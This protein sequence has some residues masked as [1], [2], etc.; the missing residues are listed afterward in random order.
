[1]IINH[2]FSGTSLSTPFTITCSDWVD[3]DV[4]GEL[5]QTAFSYRY[6]LYSSSTQSVLL[7]SSSFPTSTELLLPIGDED[8][9]F[10]LTLSVQIFDDFL[11]FTE[12]FLTVKVAFHNIVL[13]MLQN[14]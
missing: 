14:Y 6:R 12:L 10:N 1:M 2:I 7:Y 9:D 8:M 5:I 11:D 4:E 3:T 13:R